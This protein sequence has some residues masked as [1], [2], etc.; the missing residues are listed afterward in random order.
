MMDYCLENKSQLQYDEQLEREISK[1]L[2]EINEIYK[3]LSD[4]IISQDKKLD[5]IID[6]L[7]K[8]DLYME[9]SKVELELAD[10]YQ[11]AAMWKKITLTGL[12]GVIFSRFLLK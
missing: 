11:K 9:K 2:Y 3:N 8:S 4:M 6:N 7:D 10:T 1:D 5:L 12:F